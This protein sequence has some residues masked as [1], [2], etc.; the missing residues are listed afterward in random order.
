MNRSF[1]SHINGRIIQKDKEAFQLYAEIGENVV[2][3]E[4]NQS[5]QHHLRINQQD[6]SSILP[7]TQSFPIQLIDNSSF[8]LLDGGP[9]LRRQFMDWG[10]FYMEHD[11]AFHWKSYQKVLKQ[12]NSALRQGFAVKEVTIWDEELVRLTQII[13]NH[14]KSYL[15]SYLALLNEFLAQDVLFSAVSMGYRQ[16]WSGDQSFEEAL[17]LNLQRDQS[18]GYTSTGLHRADISIR[19]DKKPIK[20]VLSRGQKKLF[21]SMMK[22]AQGIL[23]ENQRQIRA[24]FLIDDLSAEL[25]REKQAELMAL[26]KEQDFQSFITNIDKEGVLPFI[27]SSTDKLFHVE[28]GKVCL[29]S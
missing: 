27:C 28:R 15:T 4:K 2:G 12:R 24:T 9:E 10:V 20:D 7:I 26:F 19:L 14:R 16:G 5:K 21:V 11:F 1:R 8:N 18:L 25:D 17:S 23:L 29:E 22:L 13:Q 6:A 3:I